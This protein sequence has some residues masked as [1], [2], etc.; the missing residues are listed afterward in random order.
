[1]REKLEE[2]KRLVEEALALLDAKKPSKIKSNNQEFDLLRNLLES[3]SWPEAVFPGQI[4]DNSEEDKEERAQGISDI[5]LPP[6]FKKKFLDF[7]CGEGHVAKLMANEADLSV[8]YDVVSS[9][10]KLAWDEQDKNFM[11]TTDFAKVSKMGPYDVILIYDVL[12][13][14]VNENP[15]DA[16]VRAAS[17]LSDEGRIYLRCHPWCGR[18][19]GHLYRKINKAFVHLVF[20]DEEMDLLGVKQEHNAK[21][22]K[23]LDSYGKMISSAGLQ[24]ATEPEIDNAT[25]EDFFRDNPLVRERILKIWGVKEWSLDPPQFQMSQCFVDYVLKK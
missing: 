22:I 9:P 10:S 24:Q 1:M 4:A 13:H 25:V 3:D 11:L 16:L 5:L 23:P 12:D 21:V 7:G 14:V 8:G 19:G 6:V 20:S 18:H 15:K 17:V 2:I